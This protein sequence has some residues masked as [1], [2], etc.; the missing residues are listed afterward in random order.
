[1]HRCIFG[2]Y[3]DSSEIYRGYGEINEIHRY[4]CGGY[5]DYSEIYR[6]CSEIHEYIDIFAGVTGIIVKYTGVL[7]KYMN[8]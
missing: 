2:G 8:T 1:M 7:V 5:R 6:D 4:I 3:R